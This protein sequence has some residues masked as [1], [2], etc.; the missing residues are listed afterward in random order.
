MSIATVRLVVTDGLHELVEL[1]KLLV[2][3]SI[4]YQSVAHEAGWS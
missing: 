1:C 2:C 3:T 4:N